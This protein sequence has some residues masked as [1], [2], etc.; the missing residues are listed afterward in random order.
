MITYAQPV[1]RKPHAAGGKYNSKHRVTAPSSK[2]RPCCG[3]NI[4]LT[5]HRGLRCL[6]VTSSVQLQCVFH[7]YSPYT[8]TLCSDN[9]W[10]LVPTIKEHSTITWTHWSNCNAL[11]FAAG[12]CLV[13]IRARTLVSLTVVFVS[14]FYP[15]KCQD[16]APARI[17]FKGLFFFLLGELTTWN[18]HILSKPIH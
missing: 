3:L 5:T 9:F 4:G 16:I 14:S 17:H 7:N 18:V 15:A 12:R 6:P 2:P 11:D 10:I 13:Q 8:H 1:W